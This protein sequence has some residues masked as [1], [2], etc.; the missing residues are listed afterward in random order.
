M[1]TRR[2]RAA[3]ASALV[4]G[5]LAAPLTQAPANA[6]VGTCNVRVDWIS[7]GS[8]Y[9]LNG[10][11]SGT[12][13]VWFQYVCVYPRTF[14]TYWASTGTYSRPQSYW[15]PVSCNAGWTPAIYGAGYYKTPKAHQA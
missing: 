4:A 7:A 9:R 10:S 14:A 2:L 5:A 13:T 8:G 11:C 3:L 15:I 12:G 6:A 1:K